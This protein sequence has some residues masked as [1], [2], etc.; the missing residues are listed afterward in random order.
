M[1]VALTNGIAQIKI[2]NLTVNI[3]VRSITDPALQQAAADAMETFLFLDNAYLD[4]I[5]NGVRNLNLSTGIPPKGT[6]GST[7]GVDSNGNQ[8]VVFGTPDVNGIVYAQGVDPSQASTSERKS[9]AAN[10]GHE[11]THVVEPG[12]VKHT[13]VGGSERYNS[14]DIVFEGLAV[15]RIVEAGYDASEEQVKLS[16]AISKYLARGD[17]Q[18]SPSADQLK[19]MGLLNDDPALSLVRAYE[20]PDGTT[21]Y[22]VREANDFDGGASGKDA[23]YSAYSLRVQDAYNDAKQD[24]TLVFGVIDPTQSLGP[25]K[26]QDAPQYSTV[27]TNIL[28]EDGTLV[29]TTD[30]VDTSGN[31]VATPTVTLPGKT[32]TAPAT[33]L[34]GA[35]IGEVFGSSIG[36]ALGGKNAFAKIAAGAALSTVGGTLG[37]TID[38]YFDDAHPISFEGALATSL[39]GFGNALG[40]NLLN[41]GTG[42]LS[43][44]LMG[45]LDRLLGIDTT[46]FGGQ[47][48]NVAGN[49]L[50]NKVLTNIA[51]GQDVFNGLEGTIVSNLPG[52]IGGFLGS[53]LAHEVLHAESA[54]GAIGGNIGG[55]LGSALVAAN[56]NRP[57]LRTA[58]KLNWKV[59]A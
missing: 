32:A 12:L 57:M 27:E 21:G 4:I 22:R 7:G 6:F 37:K 55:T 31:V 15:R 19:A 1:T 3:N 58:D 39:D 59:A 30:I 8:S 23:A 20:R 53:Y 42:A 9:Y 33:G 5:S 47:L 48:V 14:G 46:T 51:G 26:Q 2:L 45:E 10:I 36:Q 44:F 16:G 11:F 18:G 25:G 41:A 35:Q 24:G 13:L 28:T 54:I 38:L 52:A 29:S 43:G 56:D 17:G 49:T 34:T 40:H 50:L